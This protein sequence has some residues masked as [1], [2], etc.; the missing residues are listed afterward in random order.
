MKKKYKKFCDCD[1]CR[2]ELPF[3]LPIEIID[4]TL[5]G[6]LVIFAGAGISTENYIVFKDTLYD[7]IKEEL[8]MKNSDELT[9]PELMSVFCKSRVNGKQQLLERIKFRFDYCHQFSELY[10][11]AS[12]FHSEIAPLWMIKDIITTNWD[13]YFERECNAIPMVTAEDFAFYSIPQ[14]KVFKIHGSISNYGSIVATNEDYD[15]CYEQLNKGLLGSYIKTLLGTKLIVFVGYSFSDYDF[16]KIYNLIR[17]EMKDLIPHSYIITLD[18]E[19]DKRIDNQNITIINTDGSH[20]FSILKKHFEKKGIIIPQKKFDLVYFIQELRQG[21]HEMVIQEFKSNR[22]PKLVFCAMYQ[23]GIQHALDYLKFKSKTGESYD[24]NHL[25]KSILSYKL[26]LRKKI[27]KAKNYMDL[28][29]IDGYIEGLSIP[30]AYDS[31]E[32][33]PFF[34]LFGK[35]PLK[36]ARQ[37]KKAIDKNIVYHKASENYGNHFFKE[38][39][40][41]G[42]KLIPHHRPFF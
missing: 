11:T 37:F 38:L 20:F 5:R 19:I 7:D 29:Y 18:E 40:K 22:C 3:D 9:F 36:N 17:G 14:R 6:D 15:K 32:K 27:S 26:N 13:D 39:L 31:P 2:N 42:N 8:E 23:D 21:S 34:Y 30:I 33:F 10:R 16:N 25:I 24:S 41:D 4:A 1:I 12:R 28:A 35:G